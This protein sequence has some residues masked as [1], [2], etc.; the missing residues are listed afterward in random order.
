MKLIEKKD[1]YRR[2]FTGV[3]ECEGCKHRQ[4]VRG[5]DDEYFHQTAA[6][7][8]KCKK[9]GESTNSLGLTPVEIATK[10][11]EGYQV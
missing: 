8:I 9:C 10:Y 1:Q 7:K 3:Y 11:P 5:Y 4:E 6:P 2:D